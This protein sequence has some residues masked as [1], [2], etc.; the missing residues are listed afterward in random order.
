MAAPIDIE[1]PACG[2]TASH[3]CTSE[4]ALPN[5]RQQLTFYHAERIDSA[6]RLL[7]AVRDRKARRDDP[8]A[9][10]VA[11]NEALMLLEARQDL[12]ADALSFIV[13][14][15]EVFELFKL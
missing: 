14:A 13:T 1:C 2:S 7:S 5:T 11:L 12:D 10:R 3:R 15:R 4:M 6:F 8:Q 9:L